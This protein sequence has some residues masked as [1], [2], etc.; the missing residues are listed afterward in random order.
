MTDDLIFLK[1]AGWLALVFVVF[2]AWKRR[3]K[4]VR[5]WPQGDY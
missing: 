5:D 4:L 3:K 2:M 1:T